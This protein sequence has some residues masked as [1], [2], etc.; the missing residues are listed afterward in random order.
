MGTEFKS[1]RWFSVRTYYN[2]LPFLTGPRT[3]IDNKIALN[4]IKILLAI[5]IR[6]FEFHKVEGTEDK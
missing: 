4:E 1:E 6:N 2:Y 5:L 3:C